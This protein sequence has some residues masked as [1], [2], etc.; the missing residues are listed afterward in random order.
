MCAKVVLS[1]LVKIE[2]DEQLE[3]SHQI[4]KRA[5]ITRPLSAPLG[6][7]QIVAF[8]ASRLRGDWDWSLGTLPG[9][10][11]LQPIIGRAFRI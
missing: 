11:E 6:C 3:R 9:G 1:S 5:W 8:C 2:V 7:V 10:L 4:R